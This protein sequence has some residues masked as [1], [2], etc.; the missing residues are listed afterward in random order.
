MQQLDAGNR[1]RRMSVALQ[2]QHRSQTSFDPAVILLDDI[3]EILARAD[4]DN[5]QSSIFGPKLTNG[6][7]RGLI[8]VKGDGARHASVCLEALRRA[9][10]RGLCKINE[11][12]EVI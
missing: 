8:T 12:S 6:P 11:L 3:V 2:P 7:M 9:R 10:V 4:R 1:D 5:P